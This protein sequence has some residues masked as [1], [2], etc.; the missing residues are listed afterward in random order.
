MKKEII[1]PC[2]DNLTAKADYGHAYGRIIGHEPVD[3]SIENE[4]QYVK[5]C[6]GCTKCHL[7]T[8]TAEYIDT[9]TDE[10]KKY[11][12]TRCVGYSQ[13]YL[14][15]KDKPTATWLDMEGG[16]DGEYTIEV[17]FQTEDYRTVRY[18]KGKSK[19]CSMLTL[20]DMGGDDLSKKCYD[21]ESEV[22]HILMFNIETGDVR[23]IEFENGEE[24]KDCI[25]SARL[26]QQEEKK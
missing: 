11:K 24:L 1:F 3:G 25:V 23:D 17:I 19:Y 21:K 18:L 8:H 12:D 20:V 10:V 22:I 26:L 13:E 9:E 7:L 16:I 6:K 4:N 14:D 5:G 2:G 15:N